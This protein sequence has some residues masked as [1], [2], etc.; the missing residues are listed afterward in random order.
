MSSYGKEIV[1]SC[2]CLLSRLQSRPPELAASSQTFAN[3]R[4]VIRETLQQQ[5][6]RFAA[7]NESAN[8]PSAKCRPVRRTPLIVGEFWACMPSESCSRRGALRGGAIRAHR[9]QQ[10]LRIGRCRRG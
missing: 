1:L 3:V 5:L 10:L 6:R 7:V 8:G 9:R 2:G 4:F